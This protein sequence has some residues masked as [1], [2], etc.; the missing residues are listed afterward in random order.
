[1]IRPRA[2]VRPS[3]AASG[4]RERR[5]LIAILIAIAVI[6]VTWGI[7]T[8]IRVALRSWLMRSPRADLALAPAAGWT[9]P[10]ANDLQKQ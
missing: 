3:L 10:L 7:S 5:A 4:E 2:P 9:H 6:R 1:M 8:L